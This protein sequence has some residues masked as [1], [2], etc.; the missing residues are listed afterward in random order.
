MGQDIIAGFM[1]RLPLMYGFE[2][3]LQTIF[4]DNKIVKFF[5]QNS[6]S[7]FDPLNINMIASNIIGVSP[8][9]SSDK[10]TRLL[11]NT[12]QPWN[13]PTS[14][15]EVHVHSE[16]GWNMVG[17]LFPGSPVLFI[18]HSENHGW[19]HTVNSPK[20][21]DIYKLTLN[22]ANETQ[23]FLDGK[24]IDLDVKTLKIPVKFFGPIK[25][26]IT[27]KIYYSQ[28]GPVIKQNNEAFAIRYSGI[29]EMK[30]LEQWYRMNKASNLS[31][32]KSAMKMMSLPMFNT[33]YADKDGNLFYIYNAMIPDR[34]DKFDWGRKNNQTLLPG[35]FSDAIWNKYIP[36]DDLP[37]VTNPIGGFFQNC[38]A[39][40]FLA[41]G[42]PDDI[43][44]NEVPKSTGIETHQTNRSQRALETYG[45]DSS[46]TKEEFYLY[47]YDMEYSQSSVM[48][49]AINLFI[50]DFHTEETEIL[51]AI[52]LLKNWDLRTDMNSRAAA[53]AILT[54]PLTFNIA[55]Y[56]HNINLIEKRLRNSI[57][58]L[59][60][61]FGRFD[62]P[63]GQVQRL[64]RGN[65]NLPL[66]GGPGNLRAIYSIWKNG[67]LVAGI[68]DCYFQIVEWDADGTIS[69]ES[70]HQYGSAV[71]DETSIFYNNQSKLFSEKKMKPVWMTLQQIND[72]LHRKYTV[73]SSN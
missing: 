41:T 8:S 53:L 47:K 33:G 16:Q 64:I 46:I 11:L 44:P 18:G 39:S 14:W 5:S 58:K 3:T 17:G 28:H 60:S 25:W 54:F 20:L 34:N 31:E 52:N 63:L 45:A 1:H 73:Y 69:S 2:K 70:I 13:G 43:I 40:P 12:H 27:T 29:N 37:Q 36:F 35:D 30:T 23:Y 10:K 38:N 68:G 19:S 32:F 7:A 57:Q 21:V 50:K 15:Y 67:R 56:N 49:H 6:V 72:N 66:D 24:W 42:N 26:N 9:R 59:K 71:N 61:S 48:A 22:P 51:S 55:D 62:V 65:I 4:K